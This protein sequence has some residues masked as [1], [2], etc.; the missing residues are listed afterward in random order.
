MYERSTD[1]RE[2]EKAKEIYTTTKA[3][4]SQRMGIERQW[5]RGC[6][7]VSDSSSYAVS[8]EEGTGA[9]GRGLSK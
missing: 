3:S 1:H 6:Q 9:R 7:E 8:V 5:D 2:L 4:N